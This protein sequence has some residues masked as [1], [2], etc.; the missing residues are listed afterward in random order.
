[1]E[2]FDRPYRR[3]LLWDNRFSARRKQAYGSEDIKHSTASDMETI[4]DSF[5]AQ[6]VDRLEPPQYP[7]RDL[8][9]FLHKAQLTD[10]TTDTA[11][12]EQYILVDDRRDLT[13][14]FSTRNWNKYISHPPEGENRNL[15]VLNER[16]LYI[17]LRENV[18]SILLATESLRVKLTDFI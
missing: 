1:M 11:S 14:D 15:K 13:D 8:V 7:Y 3:M 18:G 17:R 9:D 12:T 4:I 6:K 5:L 16:E 10:L 2:R